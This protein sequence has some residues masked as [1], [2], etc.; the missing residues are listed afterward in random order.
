MEPF[1]T[2]RFRPAAGAMTGH[3]Y[4]IW[5]G[6]V[7]F[8]ITS[9]DM[10]ISLY[11]RI[12]LTVTIGFGVLHG[13]SLAAFMYSPEIYYYRPWEYFGDLGYRVKDMP[14]RWHGP[15]YQDQTRR[16]F[17]LYQRSHVTTVTVDNDG[18]RS[19]KHMADSYPIMVS[20]DSTIF[21]SGLSDNETLP[22]ILA[23][24]LDMPVFN[25]GRT[26][27]ANALAHPAMRDTEIVI[28][29]WTERDVRPLYLKN[30]V[31]RLQDEFRPFA[32]RNLTYMEAIR[33]I[34]PR[35]YS[36]PLMA[37]HV[38]R[39]IFRDIDVLLRDGEQPYTFL[40]HWLRAEDLDETVALVVQRSKTV[41]ATGMRYV[42]LPVPAKQTL[43]AEDVDD[44]TRNFIPTLVARLRA[45]GVEAVDLATPFQE[46]KDEGLFFPYDTHWN[47]KG[48]ALA[49]WVIARELFGD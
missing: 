37:W 44:Y 5:Y 45:E 46:H 30:A 19:R 10:N 12:F 29:G 22:W 21:G 11:L 8:S 18:F 36:L 24:D 4:Y 15:E 6:P 28:D 49:A 38:A 27:L 47:G 14:T 1:K 26:G 43:Y 9:S 13:G 23:K 40:R 2:G 31:V 39:R 25:G 35:R 34:P 7:N 32:P 16:N 48:T 41:E 3:L 17:F 20:G 33:E 42:F